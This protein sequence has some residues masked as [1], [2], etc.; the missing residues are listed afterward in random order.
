MSAQG[1]SWASAAEQIASFSMSTEIF[2]V[3]SPPGGA[4]GS[5]M[6]SLWMFVTRMG[7]G[8]EPRSASTSLSTASTLRR[9]LSATGRVNAAS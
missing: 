4:S 2:E 7:V 1:T 5:F 8:L 3:T 9:S 6:L